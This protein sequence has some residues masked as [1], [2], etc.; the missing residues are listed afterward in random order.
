MVASDGYDDDELR[1][2][3]DKLEVLATLAFLGSRD[4]TSDESL[5]LL[6]RYLIDRRGPG[7]GKGGVALED[8][9]E[10]ILFRERPRK[11]TLRE[12]ISSIQGSHRELTE[13]VDIRISELTHRLNETSASLDEAERSLKALSADTHAWLSFQ[14]LGLSSA[15]IRLPRIVPLRV[16]LSEVAGDA[17]DNVSQAIQGVLEAF[18]LKLAD[19][20][21]AIRGSWF[22]KWFAKT[23]E[24]MT[25]P[26]VADRIKKLERALEL[27]GLGQPQAEIDEKQA[28]AAAK[29][30]EALKD[31]P[32]AA[33]QVGSILLI[34]RL[35][36][37]G[38]TVQIRTL[39][40][41]EL[42][43]LENN[44]ALLM[45]PENLL[46]RLSDACRSNDQ[47]P[48]SDSLNS[49]NGSL[50]GNGEDPELGRSGLLY[51]LGRLDHE[52][53]LIKHSQKEGG[54]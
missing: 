38:S 10:Y 32:N 51:G 2:R 49:W 8:M 7:R 46:Q 17:I 13:Q 45:S 31:T 24:A 53:K 28:S 22:K 26:E 34:K 5:F 37:A 29:L 3:L 30:M 44:Q 9:L 27:K 25:Q 40:P 11:T 48:D 16:Y 12:D 6:R 35:T 21:P 47:R 54:M 43:H 15:E 14:S 20:F 42:M 39:T 41:T 50:K 23:A 33:I 52:P 4:D 1:G 36:E 19:E 18:G